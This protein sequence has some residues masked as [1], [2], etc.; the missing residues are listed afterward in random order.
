MLPPTGAAKLPTIGPSREFQRT[1]TGSVFE[2]FVPETVMVS[3]GLALTVDRLTAGPETQAHAAAPASTTAP[4]AL[5][6]PIAH[7]RT[8]MHSLLGSD[9]QR[10]SRLVRD[11]CEQLLRPPA[12]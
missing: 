11:G 5:R 7:L 12:T 2:K 3:P 6:L 8:L 1:V 4:A 10:A 9:S